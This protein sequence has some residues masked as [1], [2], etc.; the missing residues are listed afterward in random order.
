MYF[1]SIDAKPVLLSILLSLLLGQAF[2]QNGTATKSKS[3]IYLELGG[4]AGLWSLNYDR[5][6]WEINESFKLHGRA[7]LGLYSEFNGAGFPDVMVPVSGIVLW[8]A[9][10]NKW[11]KNTHRVEAGGG[12]TYYNWTLRDALSTDG[13]S[14]RSDLLGHLILGYRFQKLEGGLMF[15]VTYTPIINNYSNKPFEHWAGGSIGYTFK[16]KGR[17]KLGN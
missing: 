17:S 6:L 9:F 13:F 5:S 1:L 10:R 7:G 8:S 4:A 2:A 16:T 12:I 3:S 15:R 11:G 14:R